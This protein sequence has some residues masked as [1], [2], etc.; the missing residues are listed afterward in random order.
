[1]VETNDTNRR[2]IPSTSNCSVTRSPAD[3]PRAWGEGDR[4]NGGGVSCDGSYRARRGGS[5]RAHPVLVVGAGPVGLTCALALA[6]QRVP[7]RIV[8]R[9]EGPKAESESRALVLWRRTLRTL[10]P[11]VPHERFAADHVCLRVMTVLRGGGAPGEGVKEPE[12]SGEATTAHAWDVLGTVAFEGPDGDPNRR[13]RVPPAVLLPQAHTERLLREALSAEGV[14]VEWG[15][16][17]CAARR[18]GKVVR[19]ASSSRRRQRRRRRGKD[20]DG[21][22][23]DRGHGGVAAATVEGVHGGVEE[24]DD[25]EVDDT[26][27]E[28]KDIDLVMTKAGVSRAKA[29]NALKS[30]D[31]DDVVST[32]MDLTA[33]ADEDADVADCG[34]DEGKEGEGYVVIDG[35]DDVDER[36]PREEWEDVSLSFLDHDGR[37]R[38]VPLEC[39]HVACMLR[40][41]KEEFPLEEFRRRARGDAAFEIIED[42][43]TPWLIGCDGARSSVRSL[44]GLEFLGDSVPG[45]W[46]LADL[47]LK[48]RENTAG[49]RGSFGAEMP[50][51]FHDDADTQP[52][53]SLDQARGPIGLFPLSV[54]GPGRAPRWRLVV[55]RASPSTAVDGEG[56]LCDAPDETELERDLADAFDRCPLSRGWARASTTWLTEFG[57]SQRQ[58]EAFTVDRVSLAGDAAKVHGPF[59]GQSMNTG[60]QDAVNLA[61]RVA[62]VVK[63][64]TGPELVQVGYEQERRG[65]A[66][67]SVSLSQYVFDLLFSP[68]ATHE[69][70]LTPSGGVRVPFP[71]PKLTLHPALSGLGHRAREAAV[72]AALMSPAIRRRLAR[73]LTGDELCY[74]CGDGDGGSRGGGCEGRQIVGDMHPPA[75]ALPRG[76]LRNVTAEM[77]EG[78]SRRVGVIRGG[79]TLLRVLH[80]IGWLGLTAAGTAAGLMSRRKTP[81]NTSR[82]SVRPGDMFPDFRINAGMPSAH[83]SIALLRSAQGSGG[84]GD[85]RDVTI[86]CFGRAA[87]VAPRLF[88]PTAAIALTEPRMAYDAPWPSR[89]TTFTYARTLAVRV[90]ELISG[91]W[92]DSE[93]RAHFGGAGWHGSNGW[94]ASPHPAVVGDPR[95]VLVRT[96]GIVAA[97]GDAGVAAWL[98]NLVKA[99]NAISLNTPPPPSFFH[100]VRRGEYP[101]VDTPASFCSPALRRLGHIAT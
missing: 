9:A 49:G 42:V 91:E 21:G 99:R 15:T 71:F 68:A 46:L 28:P 13:H 37:R 76:L 40:R 62:L 29:I 20:G 57:V 36:E 35:E 7:V 50:E 54:G 24:D 59:G 4:E 86:V 23:S 33:A 44:T 75:P 5:G 6:R 45:K 19:A 56:Q 31:G 61:W 2:N 25:G 48:P 52:Y 85:C 8:D 64:V 92:E 10:D 83:D 69:Q 98:Q 14:D 12:S 66:V 72:G 97:M 58:A 1:M 3:R 95:T 89:A 55:Q 67:E 90:V 96:D 22:D 100:V 79:A 84:G 88:G 43:V 74:G 11:Y 17:L 93:V 18:V 101:R 27:V 87:E 60:I 70:W 47:E 32:I 16:E 77:V 80:A 41:T 51:N 38:R 34:E 65:A 53:I 81:C 30:N 73:R 94:C 26:G 82:L 63:G 39:E 78:I